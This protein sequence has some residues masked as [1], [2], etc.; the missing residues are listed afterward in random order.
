MLPFHWKLGSLAITPNELLVVIGAAFAGWLIRRRLMALGSTQG[1][2]LDFILAGMGGGAVGARLYYFLPLW[3]RGQTTLAALFSTW[4]D[5]S[6]FYGAFVGGAIAIALTARF[7]KMPVRSVLDEVFGVVPLGFAIGKI[8]CFLAGCCYGFPTPSGVRFA[9]GSLCYITQRGAH[10]IPAE[11]TSS[12]PVHPVQLYDLMFGFAFFAALR[13]LR[14]RSKRPG[15]VFAAC[16]AGYSLYR[17][18]IEFFRN[19]PGRDTFG[20]GPLTDSQYTAIM[21][22]IVGCIA[23]VSLRLQKLPAETA[24]ATPK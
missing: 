23:W 8:G 2:V 4:S 20:G 21:L 7:K 3:L 14:T 22:F 15:E 18:V 16:T 5:G 17:F 19:D 13:L 9:P 12:L 6:G 11:A 10:Q 24:P 1:G